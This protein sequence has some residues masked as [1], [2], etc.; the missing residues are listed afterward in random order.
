MFGSLVIPLVRC[1]SDSSIYTNRSSSGCATASLAYS[2]FLSRPSDLGR[3][4][5]LRDAYLFAAPICTDRA[6]VDAF[7]FKMTEDRKKP[8]TM[9]R[10]TSNNDAGVYLAVFAKP[11]V[12]YDACA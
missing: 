6:S 12:I 5:F 11:S 10:I 7:N 4:T 2:G 8:K 1:L 3:N 9:W